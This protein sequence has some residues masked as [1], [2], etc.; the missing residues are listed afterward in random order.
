M[1][2]HNAQRYE[3]IRS[4][5]H[6]KQP[7]APA[8]SS[9]TTE[10]LAASQGHR[11][12]GSSANNSGT[13][14]ACKV[15]EDAVTNQTDAVVTPCSDAPYCHASITPPPQLWADVRPGHTF[16]AAQPAMHLIST[17]RAAIKG[18]AC[19]APKQPLTW[20]QQLVRPLYP[21]LRP[22]SAQN[23]PSTSKPD[24]PQT[25]IQAHKPAAEHIP[26][27]RGEAPHRCSASAEAISDGCAGGK[28]AR[29][30]AWAAELYEGLHAKGC[31]PPGISGLRSVASELLSPRQ[32][33]LA[34]A[35]ADAEGTQRIGPHGLAQHVQRY[36]KLVR[37]SK[38]EGSLSRPQG[39]NR[40]SRL[41]GPQKENYHPVSQGRQL[42]AGPQRRA[43]DSAQKLPCAA[44]RAPGALRKEAVGQQSH[45]GARV[46][47]PRHHAGTPRSAT[48][49]VYPDLRQGL[50]GA[51]MRRG[52]A[53]CAL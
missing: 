49:S 14:A 24:Q 5:A 37:S 21:E 45:D 44:P 42:Q 23:Q 48:Q 35:V 32:K 8:I 38:G 41:S 36:A 39:L 51:H 46:S 33:Q 28:L 12:A 47:S 7:F 34:A 19:H 25:G 29:G 22:A 53:E 2:A 10:A 43:V 16:A 15:P 3:G 30:R 27:F 26:A 52:I 9:F 17:N 4:T 50:R 18:S 13:L 31:F 1:P 6:S 40:P 11:C 20:R